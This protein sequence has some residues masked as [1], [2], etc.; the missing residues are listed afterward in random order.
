M[1]KTGFSIVDADSDANEHKVSH[2]GSHDKRVL[3]FNKKYIK[4]LIQV[5]YRTLN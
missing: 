2:N 4:L 3:V 5:V 1:H